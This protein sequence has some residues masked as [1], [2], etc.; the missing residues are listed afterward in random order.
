M[1]IFDVLVGKKKSQ[2]Y[3]LTELGKTKADNMAGVNKIRLDII[4]YMEEHGA[5]SISEIASG[6]HYPEHQVK[7]IVSKLY[8]EQWVVPVKNTGGD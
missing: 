1:G 3:T 5:S 2:L 7:A 8:K 4:S 6:T